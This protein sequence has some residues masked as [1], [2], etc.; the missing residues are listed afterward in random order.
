MKRITFYFVFFSSAILIL[1]F[2]KKKENPQ[3]WIRINQ[4][5]YTPT[6]TKV[7]VWCSKE[8]GN[9]ESFDVLDSASGKIAFTQKAGNNF[10]EYGPFNN[11]Y[12]LNFSKFKKPGTYYLKAGSAVSPSFKID[13]DVYKGAADF[14]LFYMRQQRSN[15]NPFLKDSCHTQDGY[16]L[17][18]P[19]P[20]SSF[21]DVS[22]GWHDASDYLQY[23][24]TSANA[25]WHLLAAYRDFPKVFG[26]EKQGNGLD[27]KNGRADVLDEAKWGLDWLLKMHPKPEWM[28]NQIA[29]DR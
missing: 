14:C 16:T 12:R 17:Y 13:K 5:G 11:T 27:G 9:I 29:D 21:V 18:G 2:N 15:F 10:G 23:S 1:S 28:F 26:D 3:Q 4:L 7:A 20:D 25:T 6:G 24:T 8:A 22:G 19:M